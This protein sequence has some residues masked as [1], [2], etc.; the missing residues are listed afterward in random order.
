[1]V[2]R[3]T[4]ANIHLAG[5]CAFALCGCTRNNQLMI[6]PVDGILTYCFPLDD[7]PGQDS[8]N[9]RC[10]KRLETLG[11]AKAENVSLAGGGGIYLADDGRV[12]SSEEL[13][14]LDP[15]TPPQNR[16]YPPKASGLKPGDAIIAVNGVMTKSRSEIVRVLRPDDLAT[17]LEPGGL[18]CVLEFTLP[19]RGMANVQRGAGLHRRPA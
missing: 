5:F 3:R 13:A 1:M 6:R 10:I 15:H 9:T 2:L 17:D 8:T 12:L 11:F 4:L 18:E 16:S 7:A 19:R 14:A